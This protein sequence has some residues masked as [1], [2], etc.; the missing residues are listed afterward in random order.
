MWKNILA[1]AAL[2][3]SVGVSAQ[4]ISGAYAEPRT[5]LGSN[6]AGSFGGNLTSNAHTVLTA[7]SDQA[8]LVKTLLTAESSCNIYIDSTLYLSQSAYFVPTRAWFNAG[9]HDN[10]NVGSAFTQGRANLLVPAGSSLVIHD[11]NAA[12][13]YVDGYYVHP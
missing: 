1:F 6:P 5:S 2:I 7:P 3:L 13:Y 4:L 11:C 8:F 12:A 10:P 9:S